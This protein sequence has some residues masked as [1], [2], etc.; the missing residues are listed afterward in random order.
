[1]AGHCIHNGLEGSRGSLH[2]RHCNGHR[3]LVRDALLDPGHVEG[4]MEFVAHNL[5]FHQKKA[6]VAEVDRNRNL[7]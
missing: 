4:M 6:A 3:V 5:K 1:M 2:D 7:T